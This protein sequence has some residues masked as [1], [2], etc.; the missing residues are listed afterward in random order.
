M[1]FYLAIHLKVKKK[2]PYK[3]V[4]DPG[5]IYYSNIMD[6]HFK[7]GSETYYRNLMEKVYENGIQKLRDMRK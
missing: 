7:V 1:T 4:T 6:L 2:K 5:F 3:I